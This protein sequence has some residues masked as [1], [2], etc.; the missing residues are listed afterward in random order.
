MLEYIWPAGASQPMSI[1]SVVEDETVQFTVHS[2]YTVSGLI[3]WYVY[4]EL[5]LYIVVVCFV[6]CK[7]P[8]LCG[9]GGG[10]KGGRKGGR[11]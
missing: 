7:I 10:R 9:N 5:C 1:R 6:N 4:R 2:S 11:E 8:L 3:R